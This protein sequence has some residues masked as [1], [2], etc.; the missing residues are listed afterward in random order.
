MEAEMFGKTY[1][2]AIYFLR[3]INSNLNVVK[4]DFTSLIES[5]SII[6]CLGTIQT[7]EK[8]KKNI[9]KAK[10]MFI[11]PVIAMKIVIY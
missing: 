7:E 5:W 3:V 1:K 8:P 11:T 6:F 2:I 9:E 10:L 4:I